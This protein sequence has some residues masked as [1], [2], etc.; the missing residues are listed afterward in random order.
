MH[1][2]TESREYKFIFKQFIIV[3]KSCKCQKFELL[4]GVQISRDLNIYIK[5]KRDHGERKGEG[6]KKGEKEKGNKGSSE[7]EEKSEEVQDMAKEIERMCPKPIEH[8]F[9]DHRGYFIDMFFI[10]CIKM[11]T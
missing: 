7:S 1:G 8:H 11:F 9:K 4:F 3:K 6:Q 10:L 2:A 5:D